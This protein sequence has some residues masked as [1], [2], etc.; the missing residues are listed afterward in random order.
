MFV[1]PMAG[2]SSRFTKVGYKKP[3]YML[4]LMGESVF[5]H[6]VKSFSNYFESSFF[7]FIVRDVQNT[8]SFVEREVKNIGIKHY[9]VVC[10]EEETLGQAETVELGLHKKNHSEGGGLT[11]FNIDSFRSNFLFP[12]ENWF[13]ETDGYLEVFK[14][15][16]DNWSYVDPFLGD[17]TPRVKRTTEKE[18][19]S[20]LCSNGLYYFSSIE[21]YMYAL[22]KER[23]NLSCKELYIAPLYN[24]LI[25]KG[26][27]IHYNL[28]SYR[29]TVFC[30]TPK[31]YIMLGGEEP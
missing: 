31:E 24:H 30:G 4:P 28:I 15:E 6:S 21:H 13:H 18:P 14:G 5:S 20:E 10:L 9:E 17:D 8:I 22:S 29:D 26:K 2:L 27:K 23:K 16:G 1:I 19:I 12:S 25:E 11:I 3:K 7:L